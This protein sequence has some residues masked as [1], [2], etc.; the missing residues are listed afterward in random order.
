MC[1][2]DFK[3]NELYRGMI[4]RCRM[5]NE[6]SRLVLLVE[7]GREGGRLMIDPFDFLCGRFFGCTDRTP[8]TGMMDSIILLSRL[9]GV[10]KCSK[11][12]DATL[13]R[14]VY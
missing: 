14:G 8:T 2:E 1:R 6:K 9:P 10:P 12:E 3:K 7:G 5:I 4:R 13:D 11:T